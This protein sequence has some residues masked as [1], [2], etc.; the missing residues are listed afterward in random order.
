MNVYLV[1]EVSTRGCSSLYLM[2]FFIYIAQM[3]ELDPELRGQII[4]AFRFA[5][6]QREIAK[7]LEVPLSTVSHT[8]VRY[9]DT[10]STTSRPR[11]GRPPKLS[12]GD[13][14]NVLR[15]ITNEPD[16]PWEHYAQEYNVSGATLAKVAASDG[17]TSVTSVASPSYCSSRSTH[18]S[19]GLRQQQTSTG[20]P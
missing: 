12:D 16:H 3:T 2:H 17:F 1:R 5:H 9:K 7:T 15:D 8:V 6:A 4:G 19:T 14:R 11:S 10:G 20:R 18:A 13:K